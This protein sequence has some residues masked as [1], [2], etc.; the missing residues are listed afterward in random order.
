L[1]TT[2]SLL[3]T[4]PFSY[5]FAGA[6]WR[7][8]DV[9][10]EVIFYV[11]R[12]LIGPMWFVVL[13]VLALLAMGACFH[14]FARRGERSWGVTQV[15]VAVVA[16]S[17][18]VPVRPSLFSLVGFAALLPL[19]DRLRIRAGATAFRDAVRLL[20]PIILVEWIWAQ[21]HRFAVAGD[22]VVCAFAAYLLLA[23]LAAVSPRL[24]AILGP[25]P[26]WRIVAASSVG[27]LL[28][29]ASTL[30][31]VTGVPLFVGFGRMARHR[32][33][34]DR[35]GEW[36]KLAPVELW[37]AFP[38]AIGAAAAVLALVVARV[39]VAVVRRDTDPPFVLV[40]VVLLA[41]ASAAALQS[42]RALPY[43]VILAAAFGA[44]IVAEAARDLASRCRSL[45]VAGTQV[46]VASALVALS[47]WQRGPDPFSPVEDPSVAPVGA[48]AFATE[49]GLGGPVANS[50]DLG[51]YIIADAWP[52]MRV[53]VDPRFEM[54]YP[55]DF[56]R[57]ADRAEHDPAAFDSMRAADG[58]T[59]AMG[60]NKPSNPSFMFLARS[61]DWALVY[62]SESAAVYVLRS[63]H[64]ALEPL[65]F[66]TMGQSADV[67]DDVLRVLSRARDPA[68]L[69]VVRSELL[70]MLEASPDSWR[71]GIA[72]ALFYHLLG[73]RYDQ[74]RD[75]IFDHL[76][77]VH[78]DRAVQEAID[79]VAGLPR[80]SS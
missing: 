44:R 41:T 4:D 47:M 63:A 5:S 33:L 17:T 78:G 50:Y 30:V 43:L 70:R 35:I 23:R 14:Q 9:I 32:E 59:W 71:A 24:V 34:V 37:R 62:W 39:V 21:L 25:R 80:G 66:R 65:A 20:W 42:V 19:L 1:W 15:A 40:H 18:S 12:A 13:K 10:P 51:G 56:L 79:R 48:I 74:A 2:R 31:N 28:C 38:L 36:A 64:P 49:H 26:S 67:T 73:P 60:A 52:A 72:L 55:P 75:R 22:V 46:M 27:A 16:F 54:V 76:R 57:R 29:A 3:P 6:P 11:G 69:A 7:F 58:V 8:K 45:V 53:R 68:T 77:A 61:L